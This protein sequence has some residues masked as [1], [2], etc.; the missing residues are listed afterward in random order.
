MCGGGSFPGAKVTSTRKKAPLVS[1]DSARFVVKHPMYHLV[2]SSDLPRLNAFKFMDVALT[3]AVS[4]I[5]PPL[6]RPAIHLS[7][8]SFEAS[9]RSFSIRMGSENDSLRSP[10]KHVCREIPV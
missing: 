5:F 2:S 8:F 7:Y 10:V 4:F 3:T 6:W 9:L 1:F